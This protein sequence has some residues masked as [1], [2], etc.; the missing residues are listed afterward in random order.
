MCLGEVVALHLLFPIAQLICFEIRASTVP[1]IAL[2]FLRTGRFLLVVIA[3]FSV[4][5]I[6]PKFRGKVQAL[7]KVHHGF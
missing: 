3:G 4:L 2:R 1:K 5:K 7:I 6:V